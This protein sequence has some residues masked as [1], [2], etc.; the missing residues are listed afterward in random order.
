MV[1]LLFEVETAAEKR[2]PF[3]VRRSQWS[4]RVDSYRVE[5]SR[6]C[7]VSCTGVQK[8][9]VWESEQS[10]VQPLGPA[11]RMDRSGSRAG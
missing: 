9:I 11:G 7:D 5:L 10:G 8:L 6:V 3:F 1:L 4:D 2:L